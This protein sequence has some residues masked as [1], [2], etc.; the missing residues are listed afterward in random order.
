MTKLL[1][2]RAARLAALLALLAWAGLR[3]TQAQDAAD[4]APPPCPPQATA[5]TQSQMEAGMRQ[6]RDRG[7]LWRVTR[8]GRTSYLYGT[9]HAA[10]F[11]WMFPG[12]R[13]SQALAES[14]VVALE[15]DML[16]PGIQQQV[17][18]SFSA[19]RGA[20]LPE[21]EMKKIRQR[22]QRQMREQCLA[23]KQQAQLGRMSPEMQLATVV[24]M[25]GRR[26]G[27][28]ASYGIDNFLAGYARALGKPVLSLET[29][30]GQLGLLSAPNGR[31]QL[32]LLD[33]GLSDL[34]SG[35]ARGL[36][37]RI[38]QTWA[39]GDQ[40]QL[41]SY[42]QWCGCVGTPAE[43]AMLDRLLGGRNPAMADRVDA[44]HRQGRPV[45]AAVGSLHMIGPAG[46]P[47]LMALKGYRVERVA[48]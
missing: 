13:V 18:S 29:P 1:T 12:P 39:D 24:V 19:H 10:R 33:R 30:Q 8:D 44:L 9:I 23:P 28:D 21:A 32:T 37:L 36:L 42:E 14:S 7:F 46:L 43:R 15:L 5:P 45:F 3:G 16:D 41:E 6:A 34:E 25:A 40:P 2:Q 17:A 38:A 48:W 11:D 26:D 4:P 20:A 31:D 27:I 35:E 22:M 47:A